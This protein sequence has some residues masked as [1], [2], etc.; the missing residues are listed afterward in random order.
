MNKARAML[1]A[2]MGPGRDEAEQKGKSNEK[3]KDKTCC[4]SF[5]VGMCPLDISLLGGKRKFKVCE[6]I[7]SEMM[8][9]QLKKHPDS[10]ALTHQYEQINLEDLEYVIKQCEDHIAEEKSRIRSDVRRKKPP[11]P[12]HVNDKAAQM[13][14]E[15]SALIQ[16]AES[17]DDD[18]LREKEMCINSSNALL[19]ERDEMLEDEMKKAIEAVV[20]EE[21]CEIC[22]TAYIGS[23]G[24][25]AHLQFKIHAAYKSLRERV[26]ELRPRVQEQERLN[27][28]KKDEESKKKRKEDGD[29][30]AEKEKD[31]DKDRGRRDEK[32]KGKEPEKDKDLEKSRDRDKDKDKVKDRDKEKEKGRQKEKER[33][34]DKDQSKDVEKGRDR[35]RRKGGSRSRS[36]SRDRGKDR[37]GRDRRSRGRSGGRKQGKSRSRSR[38]KS[39]RSRSRSR[40]RRR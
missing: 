18:N 27:K 38:G 4:K 23:D 31:K 30:A 6:K 21:V 34:R 40:G 15:S 7:H 22:G 36:R 8:R 17:I 26:E 10:E 25:G 35:D 37:G 19:K 24:N 28:E 16:K 33:D 9:E 12:L 5:L 1:D 20:P 29:K 39:K 3:F 13:R 32:D 11:L 14:R 2:L